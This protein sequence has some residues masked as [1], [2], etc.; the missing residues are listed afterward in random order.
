MSEILVT[1]NDEYGWDDREFTPTI[2]TVVALDVEELERYV[3]RYNAQ[4]AGEATVSLEGDRLWIDM[5]WGTHVE[6]L[7]E[8]ETGFFLRT[9]GTP[10]EFLIDDGQ[11]VGLL[12]ARS[13]R[14][15]KIE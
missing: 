9:D 14:A 1:L 6:L 3:G 11:V 12:Y 15:E 7:P 2:K 5:P 4:G 8:S 13:I 10:L